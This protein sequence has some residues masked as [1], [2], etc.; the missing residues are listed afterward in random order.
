MKNEKKKQN[1]FSISLSF[2]FDGEMKL[3]AG[4]TAVGCQLK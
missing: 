1:Y 3:I 2:Y 4:F